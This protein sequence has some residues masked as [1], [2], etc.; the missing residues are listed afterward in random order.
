LII[1]AKRKE[2]PEGPEV[3]RMAEV[4]EITDDGRMTHWVPG[5]QI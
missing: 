3:R 2:M 5:I 4:H 1:F